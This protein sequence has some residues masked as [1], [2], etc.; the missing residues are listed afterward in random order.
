M[1]RPRSGVSHTKAI[2]E[3]VLEYYDQLEELRNANDTGRPPLGRNP[4][5]AT[6]RRSLRWVLP[7][8]ALVLMFAVIGATLEQI[9]ECVC[10]S[11]LIERR[12]PKGLSGERQS[13]LNR[14]MRLFS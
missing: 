2:L 8:V 14:H 6:E 12:C 5:W 11:S 13:V 3:A 4:G 7:L 1:D 10:G 9:G